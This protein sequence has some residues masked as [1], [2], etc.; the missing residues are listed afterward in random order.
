MTDFKKNCY[1]HAG[2]LLHENR[3]T[4]V[5]ERLIGEVCE[6][7]GVTRDIHVSEVIFHHDHHKPRPHFTL[8]GFMNITNRPLGLYFAEVSRNCAEQQNSYLA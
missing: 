3:E 5:D 6:T 8:V 4:M 1:Q 7:Y 2:L